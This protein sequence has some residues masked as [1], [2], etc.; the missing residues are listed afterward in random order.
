MD[1]FVCRERKTPTDVKL[2]KPDTYLFLVTVYFFLGDLVLTLCEDAA[3]CSEL[4]QGVFAPE[5]FALAKPERT[6]YSSC[7]LQSNLTI[8]ESG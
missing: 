4:L 6:N 2:F 1:V 5:S 7:S 3:R 8:T